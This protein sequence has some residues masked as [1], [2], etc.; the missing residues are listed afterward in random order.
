VRR[1]GRQ[2]DVKRNSAHKNTSENTHKFQPDAERKA[3]RAAAKPELVN[4]V[5]HFSGLSRTKRK[6]VPTETVRGDLCKLER[7]NLN[8]LSHEN[9]SAPTA[10]AKALRGERK[11]LGE[12]P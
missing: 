11:P 5:D 9:V 3:R 2:Q 10:E 1:G 6:N 7:E 12:N 8:R 4:E